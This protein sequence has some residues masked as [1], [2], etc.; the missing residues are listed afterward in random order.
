VWAT[1]FLLE[2]VADAQLARFRADPASPG[3]VLDTGLWRYSRHPN[4][5]GD[6]LL[7]W[8]FGLVALSTGAWMAL[9]GPAIMTV[10]IVRVSGVS[11]LERDIA[12][13]RPA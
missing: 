6:A 4:Y 8:G 12:D 3:T 2:A 5:F 7:W 13:R 11:L 10:L 1:G 9:V